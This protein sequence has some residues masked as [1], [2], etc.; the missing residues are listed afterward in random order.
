MPVTR[1]VCR[2]LI[3][4]SLGSAAVWRGGT[5]SRGRAARP[6]GGADAD[7]RVPGWSRMGGAQAPRFPPWPR[8]VVRYV[9]QFM[10]TS[11]TWLL[12][13]DLGAR[14]SSARADP[15]FAPLFVPCYGKSQL[16]LLRRFISFA[17]AFQILARSLAPPR[18]STKFF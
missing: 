12:P 2:A 1:R 13:W 16:D 4:Q 5:V 7:S 10:A 6:R 18:R 11:T 3:L 8:C 9:L 15:R 17:P 14:L